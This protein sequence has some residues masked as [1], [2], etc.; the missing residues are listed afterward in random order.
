MAG[1][2]IL[3]CFWGIGALRA[4]LGGLRIRELSSAQRRQGD[5]REKN[6]GE[7]DG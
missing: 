1:E 4:G 2:S 5:G 6:V 7:T 3:F